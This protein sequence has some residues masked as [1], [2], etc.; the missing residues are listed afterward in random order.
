MAPVFP[1]RVSTVVGLKLLMTSVSGMIRAL[2]GPPQA[3]VER[4]R[5]GKLP[6]ILEIEAVDRVLEASHVVV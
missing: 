3:Q 4:Q 2:G 6:V 5:P 1:V